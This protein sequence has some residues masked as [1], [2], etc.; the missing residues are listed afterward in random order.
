MDEAEFCNNDRHDVR[1]P[2]IRIASPETIKEELSG[3]L[4]AL[5]CEQALAVEAFL[6]EQPEVIDVCAAWRANPRLYCVLARINRAYEKDE[7]TW[8]SG[9]PF[10]VHPTQPGGRFYRHD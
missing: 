7:G 1:W 5:E 9:V 2:L 3:A 6:R 8:L 4:A 10:R